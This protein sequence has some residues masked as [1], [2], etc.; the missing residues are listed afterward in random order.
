MESLD[1]VV[2]FTV[3]VVAWVHRLAR[4]YGS[5][6]SVKRNWV[7][8]GKEQILVG[9]SM[10]A[11]CSVGVPVATRRSWIMRLRGDRAIDPARGRP[12]LCLD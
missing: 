4:V 6:L 12:P 2:L 5:V 7:W 10:G 1:F 8:L 9:M 3:V 11:L